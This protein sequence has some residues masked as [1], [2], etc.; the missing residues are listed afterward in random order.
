MSGKRN[1]KDDL[2]LNEEENIMKKVNKHGIPMKGLK[3]ASGN[4]ANWGFS[5]WH[6]QV[7]YDKLDGEIITTDHCGD[8][9]TEFQSDSIITICHTTHHM[10]MQEIA[11]EIYKCLEYGVE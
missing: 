11:D 10:T 6:T 4:T 7:S 3:K 1:N 9:W 8:G 5:G 2:I